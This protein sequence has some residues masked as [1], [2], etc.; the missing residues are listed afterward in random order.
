[1]RGLLDGRVTATALTAVVAAATFVVT[2]GPAASALLTRHWSSL[3]ELES[4][5]AGSVG[6]RGDP[7][8]VPVAT[9]VEDDLG[10]ARGLG[11]LGE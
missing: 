3:L 8:R 7:P 9:A 6:K 1:M 10:N 4:G 11:P 2:A 5:F